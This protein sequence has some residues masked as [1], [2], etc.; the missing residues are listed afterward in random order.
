MQMRIER[1]DHLG[2]IAGVMSDLGLIELINESL[3]TDVC[4]KISI[5]EAIAVMILNGLG[6]SSKPLSL[7]PRFFENK[8]L[9]LLFGRTIQTLGEPPVLRRTIELITCRFNNTSLAL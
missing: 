3:G 2:I 8:P 9:D 6:F 5:G 7:T 4:E 1:L